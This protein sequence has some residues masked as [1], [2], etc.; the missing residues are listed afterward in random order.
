MT[1]HRVLLSRRTAM[2]GVASAAATGLLPRL[3]CAAAPT[4]S[5]AE[6]LGAIAAAKGVTLGASFALHETAKPYGAQYARLYAREVRGITSELELKMSALRP[7]EHILSFDP[8]DGVF[9]FAAE[10]GLAVRGHTL[11]WNDDVPPWIK[12]LS[13]KEAGYLMDAHIETVLERYR[14]RAA[15]WD[16]VNEPIAPWDHRPDNLR[17]GPFLAAYGPDYIARSFK[18]ARQFEPS[19]KLVLN[20]AFTETADERGET[21]R[22][23]LL[24]V[25]VRLKDQAAPVD[26][27]G[28]QCHLTSKRPYDFPRFAAF[29]DEI[30]GLGFDIHL[31]ELDVEDSAFPRPVPQRDAKVAALYRAFLT[32]V[33]P[34]TAIKS[35]TLW[36]LADHTSWL[37]YRHAAQGNRSP[38][39]RPL[40]F[41]SAFDRKPAWSAIA[42][43]LKAMPPR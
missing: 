21:Y 24:S 13:P 39:P 40:P 43:A 17:A 14:G 3:G 20:E 33:L 28:L 42:D 35:V 23:T 18:R 7:A 5:A 37:S 2:A 29:L 34:N 12:A 22:R 27:V 11:I 6:T 41:D 4:A 30:A 1:D 36:Q 15:A 26:A 32:A 9:A 25:L 19:A 31:T 16:V 10:H 8:A 38:A